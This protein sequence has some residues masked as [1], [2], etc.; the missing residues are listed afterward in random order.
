MPF[1]DQ[2]KGLLLLL[3]LS[4]GYLNQAPRQESVEES[5]EET[6]I[7]FLES[8]N[9]NSF[10]MTHSEERLEKYWKMTDSETNRNTETETEII[11]EI[12][13]IR[14]LNSVLLILRQQQRL[15][16]R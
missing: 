1:S 16:R 3:M 10:I 5:T 7:P 2:N 9:V 6:Y 14:N 12:K 13:K 11:Q 4:V 8:R 15:K